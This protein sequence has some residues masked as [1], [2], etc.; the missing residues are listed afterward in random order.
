MIIDVQ[1]FGMLE[2]IRARFNRP[3]TVYS[4]NRCPDWN[5]KCG[6]APA[7]QHLVGKAADISVEGI[8]LDSIVRAADQ[9]GADGIGIYRSQG[10]CHIDSRGTRVMWEE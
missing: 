3:V 2:Y 5:T 4:G 7:S 1:L 9:A 10:F 6:G 8:D